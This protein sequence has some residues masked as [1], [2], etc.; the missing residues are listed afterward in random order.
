[1]ELVVESGVKK[2]EEGEATRRNQTLICAPI[3]ADTVDQMLNLMQKA[4]TSGADLVEVRL[5]SLKSFNPQS[6]INTIIKQSP[7][8][9]LFTYRF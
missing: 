1:M 2:M 3:M 4:K 9:T 5:D 7:L 8:P 6:N